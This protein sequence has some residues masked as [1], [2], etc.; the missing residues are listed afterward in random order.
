MVT[1]LQVRQSVLHIL[2]AMYNK[3]GESLLIMLPETIPFLAELLEG[4]QWSC[5]GLS[6]VIVVLDEDEQVEQLCQ[7]FIKIIE[8][9]LGESI[10]QYF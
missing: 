1:L 4:L 5:S 10:Q 7:K 3:L 8:E 9:L 6:W 2:M